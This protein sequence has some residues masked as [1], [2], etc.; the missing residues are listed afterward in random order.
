MRII[1]ISTTQQEKIRPEISHEI[2]TIFT[3]GIEV[4]KYIYE[5]INNHSCRTRANNALAS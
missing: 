4:A 5:Y 2:Y 3:R 1:D